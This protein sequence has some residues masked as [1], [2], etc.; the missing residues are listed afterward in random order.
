MNRRRGRCVA[1]RDGLRFAGRL[2]VLLLELAAAFAFLALDPL[3]FLER[4]HFLVLDAQFAPHQLASVQGMNDLRRF[5]SAR[6][7]RKRQ[8][9]ENAVVEMVV[10][11]I[12]QG[13]A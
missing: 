9:A 5:F 13:Q 6:E 11:R 2:F 1:R 10:E 4:E 7:V 3:A 12:G 8:T